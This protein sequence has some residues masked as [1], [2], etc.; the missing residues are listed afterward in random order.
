MEIKTLADIADYFR[1]NYPN[2][3]SISFNVNYEDHDLSISY[4]DVL[5]G[6]SMRTLNGEWVNEVNNERH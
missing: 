6:I 4:K 1:E 5:D 3:T 2:A